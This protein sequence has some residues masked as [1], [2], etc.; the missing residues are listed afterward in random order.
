MIMKW[1]RPPKEGLPLVLSLLFLCVFHSTKNLEESW[2]LKRPPVTTAPWKALISGALETLPWQDRMVQFKE[3]PKKKSLV[4]RLVHMFKVHHFT[5]WFI[6]RKLYRQWVQEPMAKPRQLCWL[7]K[8]CGL[9]TRW[10]SIQ[11]VF[12]LKARSLW[13]P[14]REEGLLSLSP[15]DQLGW[16]LCQVPFGSSLKLPD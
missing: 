6:L 14:T 15:T 2:A 12:R 1:A 10:G 11:P 4:H 8:L 3:I 13:T 16:G 5:T 7:L 9:P